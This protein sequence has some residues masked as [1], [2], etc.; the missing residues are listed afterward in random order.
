MVPVVTTDL[1]T[2]SRTSDPS[3]QDKASSVM[4]GD[5]SLEEDLSVSALMWALSLR[6]EEDGQNSVMAGIACN[7]AIL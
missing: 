7:S 4:K 1:T 6:E 2:S 3:S 5:L